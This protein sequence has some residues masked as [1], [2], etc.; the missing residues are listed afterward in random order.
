MSKRATV[1]P[2]WLDSML[3]KWGRT[4][5]ALRGWYTMAPMF[6][7][8]IPEKPAE[9][10][11]WELTPQD[12][13]DLAAAIDSLEAKHRAVVYLYYKPWTVDAQREVLLPYQVSERTWQRWLHDAARIIEAQMSNRRERACERA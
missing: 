5:P 7:G 9:R 10:G 2:R 12:F 11:M 8:T 4:M 13:D 3:L 1:E 6:K